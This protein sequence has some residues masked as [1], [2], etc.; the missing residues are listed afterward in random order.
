MV[1]N[2]AMPEAQVSRA[3]SLYPWQRFFLGRPFLIICE[4]VIV[5]SMIFIVELSPSTN[6]VPVQESDK[7]PIM[8][9]FDII[10]VLHHAAVVVY[11]PTKLLCLCLAQKRSIRSLFVAEEFGNAR[12]HGTAEAG[13]RLEVGREVSQPVGPAAGRRRQ[14]RV[15]RRKAID[16]HYRGGLP[17]DRKTCLFLLQSCRHRVCWAMLHE[18]PTRW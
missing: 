2:E 18:S 17:W 6:H 4:P 1:Y 14:C 5:P 9:I 12:V 16:R 13:N 11:R 8:F 15:Q 7:L 10:R 3:L